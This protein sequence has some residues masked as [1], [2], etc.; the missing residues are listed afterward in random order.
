MRWAPYLYLLVVKEG[1]EL[2]RG[3]RHPWI[4]GMSCCTSRS[5][6]IA[7]TRRFRNRLEA[8]ERSAEG[9]LAMGVTAI[10]RIE[11]NTEGRMAIWNRES[12][13]Y[14]VATPCEAVDCNMWI[15]WCTSSNDFKRSHYMVIGRPGYTTGG[16]N[17]YYIPPKYYWWVWQHGDFVRC[18]TGG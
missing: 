2:T 15:P 10:K 3:F 11:N 1:S 14:A 17:V 12:G 6:R 7:E 16:D 4:Y 5:L 13:Q 18:S 8:E 9:G